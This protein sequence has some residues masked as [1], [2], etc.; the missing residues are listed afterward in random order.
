MLGLFPL[1]NGVKRSEQG[2]WGDPQLIESNS[3]WVKEKGG[4]PI[5]PA[6]TVAFVAWLINTKLPVVRF[7]V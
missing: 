1:E 7:V 6:A 4:S 2:D 5:I 3:G